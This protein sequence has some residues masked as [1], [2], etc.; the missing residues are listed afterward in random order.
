MGDEQVY[1]LSN[2]QCDE[3]VGLRPYTSY[4]ELKFDN[5]NDTAN[6][7]KREERYDPLPPHDGTLDINSN[8]TGFIEVVGKYLEPLLCIPCKLFD[9]V[10]VVAP[11]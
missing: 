4:K 2:T 11:V 9:V 6:R 3:C 10:Y 5:S 8:Y 7:V 1:N